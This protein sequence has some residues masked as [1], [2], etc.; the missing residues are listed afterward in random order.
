MGP[1]LGRWASPGEQVIARGGH[2]QPRG[3][4]ASC[5]KSRFE[6]SAQG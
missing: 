1:L 2:W 5:C 4:S 3:A 6:A